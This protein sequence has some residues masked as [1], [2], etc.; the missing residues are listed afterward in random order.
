MFAILGIIAEKQ[1]YPTVAKKYYAEALEL[2]WKN[3][4]HRG[5]TPLIN[6]F[7]KL[8]LAEE[9]TE[10]AFILW[11]AMESLMDKIKAPLFP[12]INEQFENNKQNASKLLSKD[13]RQPFIQKGKAMTMQEIIDYA[14]ELEHVSLQTK[15]TSFG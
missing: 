6:R 11:G 4:E 5:L 3:G 12:D 14:L 15:N 13:K 1:E 10:N 2:R 7:F 8:A 9:Q